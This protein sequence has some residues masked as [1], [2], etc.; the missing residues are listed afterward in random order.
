[1]II[2]NTIDNIEGFFSLREEWDELL[3]SS[4]VDCL[5]LS[6]EWLYVWWS[7]LSA[8][9]TLA[10]LTV[11]RNEKLIAIA[12]MTIRHPQMKRLLPFRGMEFLGSGS[13]GSDYLDIIVRA[14][15]ESEALTALSKEVTRL[16]LVLELKFV[17][18]ESHFLSLFIKK[19]SQLGW[20]QKS[21]VI[22]RSPCIPLSAF[23]WDTYLASLSTKHRTGYL[24]KLRT[25]NRS[26][27]V[28]LEL[29]DTEEQRKQALAILISLHLK[30]WS[31][32]GGSDALNKPELVA[33]HEQLSTVAL[34]RGWLRLY[35]LRLDDV[36]AAAV[37]AFVYRNVF[38]YYQAGFEPEFSK[39][40]VGSILVG[41]TIKSA[42]ENGMGKFDFLHGSEEYKFHWASESRELLR[43][44]LF[45]PTLPGL[46]YQ[47]GLRLRK[48]LKSAL[49]PDLA[50]KA[51]H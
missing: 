9:H 39:Y 22:S 48:I 45:P 17:D 5:F 7:N 42:I 34:T 33:F 30:R 6:W 18:S 46:V 29:A 3:R 47:E 50:K 31:P 4:N 19:L 24:K 49:S 43:L 41:M 2:V 51:H 37:Y 27:K 10:I 38:Y 26:F 8:D 14:G 12:P 40:S 25:L 44:D 21:T 15:C 1:M 11:R 35:V 16:K 20:R 23:N 13:V 36:P 28:R 32:R